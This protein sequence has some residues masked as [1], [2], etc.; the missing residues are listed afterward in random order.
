MKDNKLMVSKFNSSINEWQDSIYTY[1]KKNLNYNIYN[2]NIIIN[3][4]LDNYLNLNSDIK[5]NSD[6][7]KFI[8]NKNNYWTNNLF[9]K[10][11][12]LN[13]NKL[14]NTIKIHKN[15]DL[16][17]IEKNYVYNTKRKM[18][19]L[20]WK[21][22][23][24]LN[25]KN[26]IINKKTSSILSLKRIFLGLP[27]IKHSNN[28]LLI[29]IHIFNKNKV[30]FKNKLSKLN[31]LFKFNKEN[32]ELLKNLKLKFLKERFSNNIILRKQFNNYFSIHNLFIL[33]N[34]LN[35]IIWNKS[36]NSFFK[37][38]Y[39][40]NIYLNNNKFNFLN[41][42][43]LKNI[44]S[45]IYQ[46]KV[47]LN[48]TN[49]KY[50]Y[51]ENNIFVNNLTR[52]LNDRKKGILKV[53][54]KAL[55][56][57]KIADMDP[58]LLLKNKKIKEYINNELSINKYTNYINEYIHDKYQIIFKSIRNIHVIG[59]SLEAKGRLTKRMT[60]S[61]SVYKLK[62]KG[63]LK[64]IYSAYYRTS[65]PLLR[66]LLKSN[67]NLVRSSSKNKNGSYGISSSLNT[68]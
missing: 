4:L 29:Y 35:N 8:N 62:Y 26:N 23:L 42:I 54:K 36:L 59:I 30:Y 43:N 21:N 32:K 46:K 12:Y 41:I 51:L 25:K 61:R 10:P 52:K 34:L 58:I 45:N 28:S 53:L 18:A 7:I 57:I 15:Y 65:T 48:I 2:N 56:L 37:R 6:K 13:L 14:L 55:K 19:L 24:I 38:T 60:A 47:N 22:E 67:I 11:Y 16:E 5:D 31:L 64:N 9:L 27:N 33:K 44:I 1:N 40:A 20:T 50:A 39:L 68:F 49:I 63:N 66:G 3:S 17:I